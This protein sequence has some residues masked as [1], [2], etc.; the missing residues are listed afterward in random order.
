[1]FYARVILIIRN[2]K[3]FAALLTDLGLELSI[4][5]ENVSE[6]RSTDMA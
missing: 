3:I 5:G 6:Y 4:L 2:L 1:M